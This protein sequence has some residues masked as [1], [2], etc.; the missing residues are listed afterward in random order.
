MVTVSQLGGA[1]FENGTGVLALRLLGLR[2]LRLLTSLWLLR[3]LRC[4][5]RR[6]ILRRLRVVCRCRILR[7]RIRRSGAVRRLGQRLVGEFG[8]LLCR[9]RDFFADLGQG[10]GEITSGLLSRL[11]RLFGDR[12]QLLREFLLRFGEGATGRI[13]DKWQS[14]P[15]WGF[16]E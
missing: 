14:H 1:S 9:F 2:V 10:L 12:R 5:R 6:G 13:S 11:L 4:V 3:I 15:A 7:L 16:S 8:E